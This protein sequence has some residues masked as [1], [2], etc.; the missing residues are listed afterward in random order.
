LAGE[1]ARAIDAGELVLHYQ[2]K[3]DVR[4]GDPVGVEA[5]VRWQHPERGLLGPDRFVPVA[6]Q[7]GLIKPLTMAVLDLAMAQAAAWWTSGRRLPIAVN[8]SPISLLD[9]RL[10]DDIAAVLRRHGA[11]A[12]ALEIEVT[13]TSLVH[14]PQ[15]AGDVLGRLAAM[16]IGVAI[17]DFGTGYSSLAALRALPLDELKIDRSFVAA[18]VEREED[19]IIVESTIQLAKNLR[20]R[21]VAEGV[22]DETV[23]MA[24]R[25][26]GCDV[27][28]GYHVARPQT[29]AAIELWLDRSA[30]LTALR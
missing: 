7:R 10:P 19:R 28:Q 11:P 9:L 2:P 5:L 4:S 12:Q 22:E 17:D 26:L 16:G 15:R 1:L 8:I 27:A 29:A 18:M 3:V 20:L 6:E 25:E 23:L 30:T 14:D 21:V 24:L 13:E